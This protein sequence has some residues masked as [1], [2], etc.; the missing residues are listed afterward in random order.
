M[1]K[2]RVGKVKSNSGA[3]K[4]FAKTGSGRFKM[5]KAAHNHLLQQKAKRQKRL[6]KKTL[7][8]SPIHHQT[9]QRMLPNS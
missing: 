4:R 7:L 1:G 5:N 3:K 9:L 8:T 2:A 6:F